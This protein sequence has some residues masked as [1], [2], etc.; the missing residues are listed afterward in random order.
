MQA[1]ARWL[2]EAEVLDADQRAIGP[3]VDLVLRYANDPTITQAWYPPETVI[4]PP[5]AGPTYHL[6]VDNDIEY[7]AAQI[8]RPRGSTVA[9][10]VARSATHS[11]RRLLRISGAEENAVQPSTF[12]GKPGRLLVGASFATTAVFT[13]GANWCVAALLSDVPRPNLYLGL[14]FLLTGAVLLATLATSVSV[15][16]R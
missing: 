16:R 8:A 13:T 15:R 3:V 6:K 9:I 10:D 11:P 14:M 12:S 4:A 7:L 2:E 1:T 5:V